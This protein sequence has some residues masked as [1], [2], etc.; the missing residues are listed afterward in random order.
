M[1]VYTLRKK[2]IQSTFFWCF[3]LSQIED[4]IQYQEGPNG[5]C[6]DHDRR[7]GVYRD[8]NMPVMVL[9]DTIWSFLVLNRVLYL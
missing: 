6:K 4:S 8:P 7:I 1:H 3:R 2:V 5:I 9:P